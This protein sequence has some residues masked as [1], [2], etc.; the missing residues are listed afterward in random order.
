MIPTEDFTDVILASKDTDDDDDAKDDHNVRD[1]CKT[2]ILC[3][4][5]ILSW[6]ESRV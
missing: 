5:L 1:G 6:Q 2:G 3:K 4:D